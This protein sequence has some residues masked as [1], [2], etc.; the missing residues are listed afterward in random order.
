MDNHL[1]FLP[2]PLQGK[3]DMSPCGAAYLPVLLADFLLVYSVGI[4]QE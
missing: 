4:V 2:E 1:H 3:L